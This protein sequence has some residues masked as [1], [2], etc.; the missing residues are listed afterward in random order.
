MVQ[1][2]FKALGDEEGA[3]RAAR[4]T[5][6]RAE[7]AVAHDQ[8]NG[9]AIGFAV[10]ALAT[11]GETKRAREW[12]DRALLIDPDNMNMRY[13]FACALTVQLKDT[14]AALELLGPLFS[15]TTYTWLNH[16]KKDPDLDAIREDPRFQS[17]IASAEQRLANS[18]DGAPTES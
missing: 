6:E 7:T 9:S 4:M 10:T 18:Q 14:D 11:L 1:S 8:S 2:C 12:I 16:A 15:R 5:L 17:M 13:N 3:R